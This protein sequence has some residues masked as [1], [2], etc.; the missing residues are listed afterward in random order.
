MTTQINKVSYKK[1]RC[2]NCGHVKKI[3][4]NHYGECYGQAFLRMNMCQK[5]SWKNPRKNIVWECLETEPITN[6]GQLTVNA[7]KRMK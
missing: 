1:Y 3:Q 6:Y 5:C 2:K 4:T 7:L